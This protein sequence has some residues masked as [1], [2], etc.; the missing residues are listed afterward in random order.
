MNGI[1][2]VLLVGDVTDAGP[3]ISWNEAGSPCTTFTLLLEEAG[4]EGQTFKLFVPV[5]VWGKHAEWVAETIAAGMAVLIDGRLKW[6]SSVDRQGQKQGRLIVTAWRDDASRPE[7]GRCRLAAGRSHAV[8]PLHRRGDN[9]PLKIRDRPPRLTPS[10]P[11]P[12]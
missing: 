9:L 5:E 6:R 10:P 4:K 2:K 1:N 12:L 7:C 3:K 8:E 11:P